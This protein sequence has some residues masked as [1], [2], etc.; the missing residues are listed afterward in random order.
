MER[1]R[2]A[3]ERDRKDDDIIRRILI[4]PTELD[5]MTK[6]YIPSGLFV[7]N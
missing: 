2:R 3:L 7:K 4:S 5:S 1:Q 6:K